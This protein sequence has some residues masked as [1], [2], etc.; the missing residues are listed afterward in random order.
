MKNSKHAYSWETMPLTATAT[1]YDISHKLINYHL[2][3]IPFKHYTKK[4]CNIIQWKSTKQQFK[5]LR[6]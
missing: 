3:K 4:D 6:T 1:E 2:I 5:A